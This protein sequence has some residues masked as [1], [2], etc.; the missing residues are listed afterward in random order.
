MR[1]AFS[2]KKFCEPVKILKL[3][4][5]LTYIFHLIQISVRLFTI[6]NLRY[7]RCLWLSLTNSQIS[8]IFTH[9][10]SFSS[11]L[12]RSLLFFFPLKFVCN[13]LLTQCIIYLQQRQ[14]RVNSYIVYFLAEQSE[15]CSSSY[16]SGVLFHN[17]RSPKQFCSLHARCKEHHIQPQ[18]RYF[19]AKI[20]FQKQ[21]FYV[22]LYG[23]PIQKTEQL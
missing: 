22:V 17:F 16:F 10:L 11:K 7:L 15:I 12:H 4:L 19:K 1:T 8:Q 13:L 5:I 23:E 3:L 9:S 6:W 2:Y 18:E 21:I 20:T 14:A